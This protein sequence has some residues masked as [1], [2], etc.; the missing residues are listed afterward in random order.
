[1]GRYIVRRVLQ[2]IPVLLVLSVLVF[3]LTHMAPGDPVLTILGSS[4][5]ASLDPKVVEAVRQE[6]GLDKPL[7]VQYTSYLTGLLHGDLGM[8]FVNNERVSDVILVRLPATVQ[9]AVS[10][11][12]LALLIGLPLGVFSAVK[13]GSWLDSVSMI[14]AVVGVSMPIFWLGL[15]LMLL[16]S[17]H[18]GW[19]PSFGIGHL[20]SG[21]GDVLRHL[22]LPATTLALAVMALIA[23]MT[24][25]SLLEVIGLDYMT[26]ARSKGIREILVIWRHG[27]RNA[28]IP[29]ITVVGLQFGTL[30]GGAVVTE[31]IF[32]WPG[33]GRLLL[34]A[35]MKRDYPVV[36]GITLVLCVVFVLVNLAVDIIYTVVNPEVRYD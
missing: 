14:A 25:S 31:T 5:R 2:L 10:A 6:F 19:L 7:I 29:V 22:L 33:V 18:L 8:S 20:E 27:L 32:A 1:M 12:L 13:R 16:F 34:N 23:R 30:L 15:L 21:L 36:Q 3:S 28:L 17:V 9:L 24:R 11:M 35:I 4:E 26:T